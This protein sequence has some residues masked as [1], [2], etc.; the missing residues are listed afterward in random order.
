[1]TNQSTA[2]PF[3][4]REYRL[5][6]IPAFTDIIN[7]TFPDEPTTVENMEHWERIYPKDNPR[8]RYSVEWEDGRTVAVGACFNPFWMTSP[9]AYMMEVFVDPDYCGRGVGRAL[10]ETLEPFGWAQGAE[11]LWTDCREDFARS[12]QFSQRAGYTNFGI[13]FESALDL[14]T[15][16]ETPFKS[17]FDRTAQAGYLLTT[18][19]DEQAV[20]P[21]ADHKLFDLEVVAMADV[22]FPGGARL[23]LTY[24]NWR[25]MML[26][27]P[28]ADPAGIFI[29]KLRSEYVGLTALQLPE[30]G[31]A[32]TG[33]TGVLPEHRGRG[34]AMALKLL[35]FRYAA[36][37]RYREVR[38][39]N[40][41]ANPPIL[42][43][44]E[45]LGY[46]RLPGWLVWEKLPHC[47]QA[48]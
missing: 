31:P 1:M 15:F 43:M 27:G 21:E 44:N 4:L 10:L 19:A 11:R 24:D 26:D 25:A 14:T 23:Q 7:R 36:K 17:A 35:S 12:V 47:D 13:R 6:D 9:G 42:R 37:R 38:A 30:S 20:E 29:A 39:H 33:T 48:A 46:R 3:R 28:T 22:P 40:D 2:R 34:V 32:I 45:K 5:D 18:L 8:L 16:D 41:T